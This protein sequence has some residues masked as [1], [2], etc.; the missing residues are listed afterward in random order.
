VTH[1][2]VITSDCAL[3]CC[4]IFVCFIVSCDRMTTGDELARMW[5]EAVIACVMGLGS[6]ITCVF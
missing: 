2:A 3:C 5:E 1:L 4:L 6:V